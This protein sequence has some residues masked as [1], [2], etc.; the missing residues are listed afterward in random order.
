[1]P[2]EW[3]QTTASPQS[4]S[5]QASCQSLL[6]GNTALSWSHQVFPF[7]TGI[8][9]GPPVKENQKMKKKKKPTSIRCC[10]VKLDKDFTMLIW[11]L[12]KS[13]DQYTTHNYKRGGKHSSTSITYINHRN[14]PCICYLNAPSTFLLELSTEGQC[15][16]DYSPW[17]PWKE[18]L[19]LHGK[20]NRSHTVSTEIK[21]TLRTV[22]QSDGSFLLFESSAPRIFSL[23]INVALPDSGHAVWQQPASWSKDR[24]SMPREC[25]KSLF[26]QSKFSWSCSYYRKESINYQRWQKTFSTR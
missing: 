7:T 21:L 14:S 23:L 24:N 11:A 22:D 25:I 3:A 6:P 13:H 16:V 9:P 10:R 4:S 20:K 2:Q 26:N 18:S 5:S 8:F 12:F 17:Q 15:F 1:M 19:S